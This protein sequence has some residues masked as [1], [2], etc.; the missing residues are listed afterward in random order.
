TAKVHG[1]RNVH[2]PVQNVQ[3]GARHLSYLMDIYGGDL[4]RTLAAYNAGEG[5]VERYR[6]V[7]PYDETRDYVRNI[8]AAYSRADLRRG[9][10]APARRA[11]PPPGRGPARSGHARRQ[12]PG[13]SDDREA[14]APKAPELLGARC[15]TCRTRP[16]RPTRASSSYSSAG[17][18]NTC[19]RGASTR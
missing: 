12:G 19:A 16:R 18:A 7:P 11:L 10:R 1:V 15:R 3:A 6:G 8:L 14:R 9:L 2:D 5:A 13:P 4:E 17:P